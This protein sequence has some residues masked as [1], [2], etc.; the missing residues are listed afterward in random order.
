MRDEP[1]AGVVLS[2]IGLPLLSSEVGRGRDP[3]QYDVAHAR[4]VRNVRT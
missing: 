3:D 4:E 1:P 2:V